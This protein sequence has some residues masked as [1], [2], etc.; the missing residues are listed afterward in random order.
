MVLGIPQFKKPPIAVLPQS[1]SLHDFQVSDFTLMTGPRIWSVL[2]YCSIKT[3][4]LKL[5]PTV[6][7]KPLVSFM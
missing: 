5:G 1:K 2:I 6:P 7:E 3:K 4:T